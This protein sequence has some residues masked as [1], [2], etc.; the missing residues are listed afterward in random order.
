MIINVRRY[1]RQTH[2]VPCLFWI[3]QRSACR[4]S[5]P[6]H[7]HVIISFCYFWGSNRGRVIRCNSTSFFFHLYLGEGK[8]NV[9][10]STQNRCGATECHAMQQ[11]GGDISCT[12]A[13]AFL[14]HGSIILLF[15]D[16]IF[17]RQIFCIVLPSI[18]S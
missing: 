5:C 13:W 1:R 7:R 11:K 9:R 14:R 6:S 18:F 2:S 4:H 17:Y 8:N 3:C 12:P 16:N 15:V 10:K